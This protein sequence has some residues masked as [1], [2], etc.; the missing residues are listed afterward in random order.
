MATHAGDRPGAYRRWLFQD[1]KQTRNLDISVYG[2]ADAAHILYSIAELPGEAAARSA[3]IAQLQSYQDPDTGMFRSSD[4]HT[5]HTTAFCA[6]A[7]DLF[8]ARPL[9]P[10]RGLEGY[11]TR[12]GL[13]ALLDGLDWTNGP[14]G[15]S[16]QGAGIFGA[17]VLA[18]PAP[19]EWQDWYFEWL[20]ENQDP[21]T[22][23]WRRDCIRNA[24]GTRKGAPLFDHLASSFHYLFNH[25]FARRPLRYSEPLVDFCLELHRSDQLPPM[26]R[27]LSWSEIDFLYTLRS[28]QKRTPYRA[29]ETREVIE[30]IAHQLVASVLKIDPA[31]DEGLNDLH[32]LFAGLSSLAVVQESLP[33]LIRTP[34]PLRLV[35]DRRPFL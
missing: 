13:R 5:I 30:S 19:A 6:G 20:W 34:K 17:M 8:D 24:D 23:L 26:G 18:G 11:A 33:G 29:N 12:T 3:F 14:W 32:T 22:G 28:L 25:D 1:T 31:R 15:A 2:C 4:H 7:L 10:M 9:Y 35:L 16:H 27:G 21:A